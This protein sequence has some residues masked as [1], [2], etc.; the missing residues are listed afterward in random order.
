MS[1]LRDNLGDLLRRSLSPQMRAL[2]FTGGPFAYARQD[3]E[4]WTSVRVQS[5]RAFPFGIGDVDALSFTANVAISSKLLLAQAGISIDRPPKRH[6]VHYENRIGM[7]LYPPH[8]R[9]WSIEEGTPDDERAQMGSE[10]THAVINGL[11][12]IDVYASNDR[13]IRAWRADEHRLSPP[14]RAWLLQLERLTA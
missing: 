14:E 12:G 6:Q 11:A 13:L 8:D 2:E 1:S 7:F 5:V 4:V 9:W 3:A 10:F